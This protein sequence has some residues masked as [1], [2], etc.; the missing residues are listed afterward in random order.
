[1]LDVETLARFVQ[2]MAIVNL[3]IELALLFGLIN[4]INKMFDH[5]DKLWGYAT[6]V[7]AFVMITDHGIKKVLPTVGALLGLASFVGVLVV[8]IFGWLR[9]KAYDAKKQMII[10]T[11]LVGA[12]LLLVVVGIAI[13]LWILP[14]AVTP[15]A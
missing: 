4:L 7:I 11:L 2:G 9:Y 1:M 10:L 3:L 12:Q 6:S 13:V 15:A 5:G 8:V 14:S